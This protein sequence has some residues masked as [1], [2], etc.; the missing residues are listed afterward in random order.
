MRKKLNL[1]IIAVVLLLALA[2]S[3]GFYFKKNLADFFVS[4]M[5]KIFE[6]KES[7]IN[8]L[9]NQI[10]QAKKDISVPPPLRLQDFGVGGSSLTRGGV[11]K[12]TNAQRASQGLPAL[13]ENARLDQAANLKAQDMFKNQYFEHVSPLGAGPDYLADKVGYDFIGIG[14]N[15]ATGNY[16]DDASLVQA[17]MASPGHRA[18]ILNDRYLDIGVA[19]VRGVFEGHQTWM[20]VQEF[21]L[22]LAACPKPEETLKTAID[23]YDLELQQIATEISAR[24]TELESGQLSREAYNQKVQVYNNLV[25]NYNALL[26]AAKTLVNQYNAEVQNFNACVK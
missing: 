12:L 17:W 8:S 9:I 7:S 21:G 2:L 13:A 15:L 16:K 18:N 3:A 1:Y 23:K 26:S 10:E 24:K 22:P 6:L 19:V 14:E 25:N 4:S 11:I 20:A 5:N